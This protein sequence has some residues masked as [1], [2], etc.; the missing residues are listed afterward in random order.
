MTH[1]CSSQ[2]SYK[3]RGKERLIR[4]DIT[5]AQILEGFA[6]C[7]RVKRTGSKNVRNEGAEQAHLGAVSRRGEAVGTSGEKE[8]AARSL[9]GKPA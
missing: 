8:L 4:A 7:F 1:S 6:E 5:E 3:M 9:W 2:I